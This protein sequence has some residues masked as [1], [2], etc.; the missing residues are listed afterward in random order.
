MA[1]KY[2]TQTQRMELGSRTT[3]G[4]GVE[5]VRR[6]L[7]RLHTRQATEA[8]PG[9]FCDDPAPYEPD[10]VGAAVL[11]GL[12][13]AGHDG[14]IERIESAAPVVLVEVPH[15]DWIDP[16]AKTLVACFGS[17]S[18][19]TRNGRK[20][21]LPSGV[22]SG[23]VVV[24]PSA[25]SIFPDAK[26]DT[27]TAQAFREHRP[28]IGV[29]TNLQAGLPGDLLRACE[30]RLVIGSFDPEAVELLIEHVIG[31]PAR[32]RITEEAALAIEPGDLRIAI[33]RARGA[34]GS[35]DR[36]AVILETR[37]RSRRAADAPRLQDLAGYGGAAEWGLAAAA[38]LAA[39]SRNAIPWSA[40]EPGVL[41]V[42]LPGTGKTSF[43]HA[44]ARQADVPL[45][46]GSL[47]QWQS[48]GEAHLGTTLKAMREFF[49]A[50][51]RVSPCVALID[52]LD[53]FG[54]RRHF[55]DHNRD[56]STQVVNG[57]LEC[58]D[59][60]GGRAGVLLVGTTN[61][62]DRIDPAILRSGRFDRCI[63]IPLPSLSD[64]A[65]ILR[66]HLGPD[67]ADFDLKEAA[68][69][70]LGGTGADCAAWVRRS[71]G[72]AR[73]ANRAL[74][75]NDLLCE[76][77][78]SDALPSSDDDLRAAVHECG[79][80]VVAHAL[81]FDLQTI[82]IYRASEGGGMTSFR[83]QERYATRE[84]LHDLLAV[85][86]AGRAAEMLVFGA[87]STG[88][89]T[90]LAEATAIC[91]HMHCSWGLGG[92]IAVRSHATMP[93]NVLGQ[94]EHDL[95]E[96]ADAAT[97]ILAERRACLDALAQTLTKRRSLERPEIEALLRPPS[98]P[99]PVSV[100]TWEKHSICPSP[101]PERSAGGQGRAV[102]GGASPEDGAAPCRS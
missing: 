11:L 3:Q 34:D 14:L 102:S 8:E 84:S 71:R 17:A 39:Y 41:L 15:A 4:T 20:V 77:D 79:H 87:P 65:A 97:S 53:S 74:K 18:P 95:R 51:R 96:A 21:H 6:L 30:E 35:L 9:E 45:L 70:A 48:V 52:E 23:A 54:D 33:H 94:V 50:A 62:R 75:I 98:S 28:L 85:Y 46:V 27:R 56:Y 63:T 25:R 24:T 43:A 1:R 100:G 5:I 73:R 76:I 36:L 16:M 49:D 47:A 101:R 64:L 10:V 68:R 42:G 80:T 12:G 61:N 13:L 37:L 92:Q 29:A 89:A 88:S 2:R 60:H 40:C 67:L 22:G 55:A 99:T 66:H 38:D 31:S 7:H 59:G 32:E 69:R 57:F 86:L 19:S 93:E 91:S 81:G 78:A 72:R 44:L 90:D 82:V 83:V 26:R 58:L